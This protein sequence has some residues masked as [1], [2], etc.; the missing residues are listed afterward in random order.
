LTTDDVAATG[1]T[2]ATPGQVLR[3]YLV[4]PHITPIL[5]VLTTTAIL[6]IVANDG[7]PGA[8]TSLDILLAM[9]GGQIAIGTVNEL[10]DAPTDA[11]VKPSKPTPAGLVTKRGATVL[12]LVALAGMVLFAARLGWAS[13]V[14]CL[15]GTGTGIAYSVWF[16]RTIVAWFPYLVALP[17]LPIWVFTAVDRFDARLLMLY[18]LGVFAVIG[19]YLSQSLPDIA[20][21]RAS[22]VNNLTS[23][24][25]E[26]RS[27]QLS[28]GSQLVSAVTGV[29]A[30]AVWVDIV[31]VLIAAATIAILS[32]VV[33]IL[34][35]QRPRLGVL[36]CFPCVAVSTALLGIAWVIGLT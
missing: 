10:I 20:A 11:Q 18:P 23:R 34:Y 19:V 12:T 2:A 32:S 9:L 33:L 4:L 30:A 21:D 35:R 26:E 29:L 13:L 16:K 14:L 22:G 17:L 6:T 3:A 36:A 28:L 24:L 27:L 7:F 31:P 1:Q 25:G 8:R 15:I 5:V